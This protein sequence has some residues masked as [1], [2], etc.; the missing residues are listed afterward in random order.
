MATSTVLCIVIGCFA[1]TS[2]IIALVNAFHTAEVDNC[3]CENEDINSQ[4]IIPDPKNFLIQLA[5]NLGF[6]S[7]KSTI[8]EIMVDDL[9]YFLWMIEFNIWLKPDEYKVGSYKFTENL[10]INDYLREHPD[11]LDVILK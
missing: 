1:V 3:E 7:T 9:S 11:I 10:I 5:I 4:D 8:E 6:K 2:G